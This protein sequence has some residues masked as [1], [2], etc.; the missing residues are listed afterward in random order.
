MGCFCIV[1][2][3]LVSLNKL[4]SYSNAI[5]NKDH[6]GQIHVPLLPGYQATML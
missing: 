6:I 2:I 4:I 3:F 1:Y 5:E